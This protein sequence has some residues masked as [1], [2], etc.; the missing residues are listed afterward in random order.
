MK[1]A[2]RLMV[3]ATASLVLA[4]FV[5]PLALM[6]RSQAEDRAVIEAAALS[7]SV[8]PQ[9]LAADAAT[10]RDTLNR[11]NGRP[12]SRVTVFLPGGSTLGAPAS[13]DQAVQLASRGQSFAKDVRDGRVYLVPVPGMPG[14]NAVIRVLVPTEQ[15]YRG[16]GRA[17]LVLAMISL[18]LL[19]LIMAI[20]EFL[21]RRIIRP[22]QDLLEVTG[23]LASGELAARAVPA[24]PEEIRRMGAELN[25]FAERVRV[26]LSSER[27][28]TTEF[29]HKLRSAASPQEQA[30]AAGAATA[31]GPPSSPSAGAPAPSSASHAGT[32][33][34]SASGAGPGSGPRTDTGGMRKIQSSRLFPGD[35]DVPGTADPSSG[36]FDAIPEPSDARCCLATVTVE[37]ARYWTNVAAEEGRD[38]QVTTTAPPIMVPAEA[39]D[40]GFVIDA[41]VDNVLEH[42]PEGTS[43]WILAESTGQGGRLI[44]ED[45]GPGFV[46]PDRLAYGQDLGGYDDDSE[47]GLQA[48]RRIAEQSGGS[49]TLT[50]RR[51]GGAQVIVEFG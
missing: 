47:P 12:G 21:A 45:A 49:V 11:I 8:M 38:L 2:L 16:V 33:P 4:A 18:L 51:G 17:W 43:L 10:L 42:T 50:T 13:A 9:V 30:A 6:L 44:V 36:P 20:G 46:D 27:K 41:L 32:S 22:M 31:P 40:V 24:G 35:A 25:G 48:I 23:R 39:E 26:L 28:E 14:G 19:A 7:Q 34:V 5:V 15:L 3:A 1:N 29:A 37:R